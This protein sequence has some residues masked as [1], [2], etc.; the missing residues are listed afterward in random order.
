[1][2]SRKSLTYMASAVATGLALTLSAPAVHAAA[3]H[4]AAMFTSNTLARNDDGSTGL[5]ATGFNINFFGSNY[6]NLYVNNNG[7]V[8]FT[9]ALGT[10]TPFNI[11]STGMPMLAPFFADI[12]TRN[13]NSGVTQ[14]GQGTLGGRNAFGVNWINVGYYSNQADK[15]NS[16]QLIMIDRSD[17]AAGDFDFEFNYDQ[18]LWETGS[19]S[20]GSGGFGGSPARAGWSSGTIAYEIAGSGIT[21]ALL[22]SNLSTGLI[23][24]SLNSNTNGQYIFQVRNGQIV[25]VPEPA[26]L[27]LLGLGLAGL[28]ASRK[29]KAI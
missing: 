29:R 13:L 20:G 14:Y 25:Q 5:V 6:S 17:V 4:D 28:A 16:I 27:A 26:S 7:N 8:T 19:A 22:D 3:I 24:N 2:I 23:H 11:V 18:I 15:L 10:Y 1:M 9:A 12:D 21:R